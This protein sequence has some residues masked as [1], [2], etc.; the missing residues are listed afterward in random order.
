MESDE[1]PFTTYNISENLKLLENVEGRAPCPKCNKSRKFFCYSCYIPMPEIKDYVPQI[2][3]PIIKIDIVKHRQEIE[4]KSTSAH[5]AIIAPNHV[6]VFT[7][8]TN[9]PTY[10]NDGKTVLI[11]PGKNSTSIKTYL[12][13]HPVLVRKKNENDTDNVP[14]RITIG[15]NV[16]EL[17]FDKLLFVDGTWRQSRAMFSCF[18]DLPCV[19]LQTRPSHFWRHQKNSPR[20][21]L[22][23]IE[24][25]HQSLHEIHQF[26]ADLVDLPISECQNREYDN[27]LFFFRF[28]HNVIHT[29]YDHDELLSYRRPMNL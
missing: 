16:V 25:L 12:E 24:A 5:A 7:F 1:D 2:K 13:T 19:V 15:D 27:L 3:L 28:M 14:G 20:W 29:L 8:P 4:G 10:P 26:S 22:A 18:K 23:T 21:Y 11:Y 17:P 6:S 9:V